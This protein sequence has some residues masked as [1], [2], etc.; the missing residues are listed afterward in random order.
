MGTQRNT[1]QRTYQTTFHR[2]CIV[3]CMIASIDDSINRNGV[4]PDMMNNPIQERRSEY[5]CNAISLGGRRLD[6]DE[7]EGDILGVRKEELEV[8][9]GLALQPSLRGLIAWYVIVVLMEFTD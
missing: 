4:V 2:V 9:R 8:L 5:G 6:L 1:Q 3:A 7:V